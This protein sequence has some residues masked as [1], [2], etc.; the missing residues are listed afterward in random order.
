MHRWFGPHQKLE[1]VRA[2]SDLSQ[3]GGG[4]IMTDDAK[5]GYI[6]GDYGK[7]R[8]SA[9]AWAEVNIR[10]WGQSP[11]KE[12][13]KL[14]ANAIFPCI[15][16]SRQI[17]VGALKIADLLADRLPMRVI[18]REILEFMA[19]EKDLTKKAVE[20]FDE[21]YPGIM[22]ELF[23]MLISEK[24]Y[25]KSDY[26]RHLAKTAAVLAGMEPTIF[27]G[28]GIHLILPRESV[29]AVRVIADTEYRIS[30]L[31]KMLGITAQKAENQLKKLDKEQTDFFKTIYNSNNAAPEEFDL[32]INKKHIK[33]E[34]QAAEIVF[35]AFEQKFGHLE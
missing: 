35:C 32:V 12:S 21:K 8:L 23:T 3:T 30:R 18:D 15:C 31:S 34:S 9:A 24:T 25:L 26:A 17:G 7:K 22:S 29:L 19:Q 6:P 16:F 27:V 20:F 11:E 28:R 33:D 14:P 1:S 5:T 4:D 13:K 10:K 2:L